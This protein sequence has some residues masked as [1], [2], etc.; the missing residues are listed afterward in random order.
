MDGEGRPILNEDGTQKIGELG[1]Q[2]PALKQRDHGSWYYYLELP[3]GVGGKRRRARKGGFATKKAAEDKAQEIL[4]LAR[5]GVEVLSDETVGEYLRRWLTGKQRIKKS[6]SHS[7]E[8]YLRLYF[9]PHLGHIKLR[10]LR[11]RHIEVMFTEIRKENEQRLADQEAADRARVAEHAAHKAWRDAHKPRPPELRARWKAAQAELKEALAKPRRTTE[12]GTQDRIK[13]AL[14]SA[15]ETARKQR[16]IT[17][18]WVAYVELPSYRPPRPMVWTASRIAAWQQTGRKPGP[19]MVWR[20][21]HTG[22]FLDS[23]VDDRLY[24]LW[25]LIAFHGLRRGEACA[26][27]WREVDF[28]SGIIRIT[29]QIVAVAYEPHEGTP[30]SDQIRDITL[31]GETLELLRWWRARQLV[32]RSEWEQKHEENPGQC[33]PYADSGR[34]FTQEG[35]A[36]Y[37]PQFFSDR[38][39]RLHVRAAL[40]PV[41]LHDLRHGAATIA[42]L[43][44]VHI[45]VVQKKLG[46]SSIKVTGD[47]YTSVLEEVEKEAAEATLAAVPRTRRKMFENPAP[48]VDGDRGARDDPQEGQAEEVAA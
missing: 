28:D 19:V 20:P 17:D 45:K 27:S 6:T 7:Y 5:A 31:D 24:P 3:A 36:V 40:P 46:H 38:F 14:S 37:H 33:G 43:A 21:E 44:G 8:D 34:V 16:L 13:R 15:L 25:H 9:V 39:R 12:A 4:D 35:G 18:N 32:E 41:R 48:E 2:C 11:T 30:K 42:L 1:T 10:D 47:I 23:V 29:E 22:R 26:L